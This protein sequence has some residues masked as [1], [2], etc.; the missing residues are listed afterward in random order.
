MRKDNIKIHINATI[1]KCE[2][3]F[4]LVEITQHCYDFLYIVKNLYIPKN[5]KNI[6]LYSI[7]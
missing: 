4:N 2:G 6:L 3:W 1:C 7:S 5:E